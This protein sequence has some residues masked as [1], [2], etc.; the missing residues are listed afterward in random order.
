MIA[1]TDAEKKL[2]IIYDKNFWEKM[3]RGQLPYLIK[4]ITKKPQQ[5]TLNLIIKD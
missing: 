1:P 4:N 3:N 5:Q 2:P